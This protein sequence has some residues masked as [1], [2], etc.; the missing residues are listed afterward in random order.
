[1]KEPHQ[2][3]GK[4]IQI[5]CADDCVSNLKLLS[6]IL[7]K[8]GYVVTCVYD[9]RQALDAITESP[10]RFEVLVTDHDMPNMNGLDLI[11]RLRDVPFNGKIILNS[12]TVTEKDLGSYERNFIESLLQKPVNPD[13]LLSAVGRCRTAAATK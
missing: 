5:L 11:R 1:M 8:A 3:P 6:A 12:A 7:T 2:G 9:G 10:G 13:R 4:G